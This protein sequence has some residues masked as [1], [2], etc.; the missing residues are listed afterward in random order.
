MAGQQIIRNYQVKRQLEIIDNGEWQ[1]I[2]ID[3]ILVALQYP[4]RLYWE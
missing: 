3:N 2:E 4:V 1:A